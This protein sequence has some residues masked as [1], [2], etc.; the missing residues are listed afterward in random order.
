MDSE[1]ILT[2]ILGTVFVTS[3]LTMVGTHFLNKKH[4]GN[5]KEKYWWQ[6]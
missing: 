4:L 6:R 2:L 1:S 3:L 5:H